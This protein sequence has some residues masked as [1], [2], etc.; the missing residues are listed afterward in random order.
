MNHS[1]G[2][3]G[4]G[5]PNYELATTSRQADAP[6]RTCTQDWLIIPNESPL[7]PFTEP[8]ARLTCT[9]VQGLSS[10]DQRGHSH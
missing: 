1:Q 3:V 8:H 7:S 4:T 10:R 2:T 9:F 6:A 5:I